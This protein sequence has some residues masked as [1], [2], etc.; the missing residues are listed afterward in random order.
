M[1]S[2][3]TEADRAQNLVFDWNEVNRKGRIVSKNVTFFDETLRDGLQNP[4]VKDPPVEE[5]LKILHLM[6]ALGIQE[7]DIGLPGSSQRAFEDVLRLCRE[8]VD[9]EMKLRNAA[10]GLTVVG[11]VA[12]LT[13]A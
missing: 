5:K 3:A 12:A 9:C 7:A 11:D 2:G 13:V 1:T 4:S 8:V 6:E 10:V